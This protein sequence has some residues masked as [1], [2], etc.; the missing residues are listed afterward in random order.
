[1]PPLQLVFE[2]DMSGVDV[3]MSFTQTAPDHRLF[4]P[5]TGAA[6]DTAHEQ[7]KFYE[8]ANEAY[9]KRPQP[10][11]VTSD[12]AR[13]PPESA[14]HVPSNFGW[15]WNAVDVRGVAW[16]GWQWDV[17][18]REE[19]IYPDLSLLD[20]SAETRVFKMA[21]GGEA[22]VLRKQA[23][24]GIGAGGHGASPSSTQTSGTHPKRKHVE[25]SSS[26][27][28]HVPVKKQKTEILPM[29]TASS[30]VYYPELPQLDPSPSP[31]ASFSTIQNEAISEVAGSSFSTIPDEFPPQLAHSSF[32][33]T[34]DEHMSEVED[35][36][37]FDPWGGF[38]EFR[39]PQWVEAPLSWKR[40]TFPLRYPSLQV[41]ALETVP[42]VE[43]ELE[44]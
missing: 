34:R 37:N 13:P 4:H 40:A 11:P 41:P 26:T 22:Q 18:D 27:S 7:M 10:F 42:E 5:T 32:S 16:E 19:N 1:M 31:G 39:T 6:H 25:L 12:R 43:S 14:T 30:D 2:E 33:T 35:D 3:N 38:D 17:I 24:R 23:A 36:P 21:S 9:V 44:V 20:A 28:T 8:T 29:D 15:K